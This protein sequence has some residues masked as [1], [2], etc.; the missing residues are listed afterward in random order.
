M[1]STEVETAKDL[2]SYDVMLFKV[3]AESLEQGNW[4]GKL[5]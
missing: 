1:N 4:I 3:H 5:I 2:H